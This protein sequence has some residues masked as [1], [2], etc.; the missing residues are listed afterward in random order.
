MVY[1]KVFL[2]DTTTGSAPV[3]PIAFI[4][5]Q[6]KQVFCRDYH[7]NFFNDEY[8]LYDFNLTVGDT[9]AFPE[10]IDSVRMVVTAVNTEMTFAG[11]RK[12][13]DFTIINNPISVFYMPPRCVECIGDISNGIIPRK[14]PPFDW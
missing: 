13:Y 5:E 12:A 14:V 4:R 1:H 11:L 10:V 3:P 7:V 2:G 8:L 9:F 6:N